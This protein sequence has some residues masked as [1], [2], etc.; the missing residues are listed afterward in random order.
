MIRMKRFLS[1]ASLLASTLLVGASTQAQQIPSAGTRIV[2]QAVVHYTD[3]TGTDRSATTNEVVLFVQQ[4]YS[5]T[6]S[7]DQTRFGVV[8]EAVKFSHT[9]ENTGNGEDTFCVSVRDKTSGDDGNFS[10][11]E[12]FIDTNADGE[13]DT[14]SAVVTSNSD[15]APGTITLPAGGVSNLIIRGLIPEDAAADDNF[16]LELQVSSYGGTGTCGGAVVTDTGTN[17]DATDGTNEDRATVTLNAILEITKSSTYE[18]GVLG[19]LSDDTIDYA[20]TVKN[21]G[22]VPATEVLITDT[23]PAEV[24]FDSFGTHEGSFAAGPVF[25]AGDVTAEVTALLS[26]EQVVV[27]FKTNVDPTLGY[28]G[29]DLIIENTANVDANIDVT[30]G[31]DGITE[32]NTTSDEIDVVYDVVLSDIGGA[33][34]VNTNDGADDD[35]TVN[36]VQHVDRATLGEAVFFSLTVENTGNVTD[37]YNFVP[38]TALGWFNGAAVRYLHRDFA[39]PLLDTTGEGIADSGPLEPGETFSFVV[40]VIMP[41]N[42]PAGPHTLALEA[43][44]TAD[45][46]GNFV[47]VD[48]G[49]SLSIGTGDA[50]GVDIANSATATG[51]DDGGAVDA[52]PA[53]SITTSVASGPGEEVEFSLFVANEGSGPDTFALSTFGDAA[54]TAP[55]APGWTA[56]FIDLSGADISKTPALQSGDVFEFKAV[57]SS[58]ASADNL[59]AE[60]FFFVVES[61]ETGVR[62]VKQD[63]VTI[64]VAP[65][66]VLTPDRYGQVAPCGFKEYTHVLRN[67]GGTQEDVSVSISNQTRLTSQ[68]WFATAVNAGGP[69]DYENVS[70]LSVGDDVGVLVNETWTLVTLISDGS[71]GLA[72]PLGVGDE[73]RLKVRVIAGCDVAS[74]AVDVLTLSV[75][76]LD[77]DTQASVNDQTTVSNAQL[78]IT[79]LGALDAACDDT[80]DGDFLD[81]NVKASPNECVIWEINLE[82]AGA[83]TVCEVRA[84]D[85]A[86]A[87]TQFKGSPLITSQPSPGTGVCSVNGR[88]FS[89]SVGNALDIDGDNVDESFCL[90]GGETAKVH[91]TV[92]I[93]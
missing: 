8:G 10:L 81:A 79:K 3:D 54:G 22:T 74:G 40:E 60:S 16:D 17:G 77:A 32:S 27:R 44:S 59:D 11:L 45:R 70:F 26:G 55:L 15:S 63:A 85:N 64:G 89:C 76:S 43:V 78:N 90:R 36:D 7:S 61:F 88:E 35:G 80:A 58:P 62:D 21:I 66:I 19:D 20:I 23:I 93:D 41:F 14:D 82:N 83:E 31:R 86:P 52:D 87:F 5:G 51:L 12:V 50:A 65:Q 9:L 84:R 34:S 37:T 72:I 38:G 53:S 29:G 1:G 24:T 91:F 69:T 92:K 13:I 25:L 56:K 46:G 28:D 68:L 18:P 73:T 75:A 47:N 49:T 33:P 48:D 39:T 71:G 2:N 30:P 4:V 67:T 6:I 42:E 57:V